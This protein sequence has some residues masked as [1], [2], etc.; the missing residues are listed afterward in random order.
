M[1]VSYLALPLIVCIIALLLLAIVLAKGRRR[2][3]GRVFS[4]ILFMLALYG[5]FTFFMRNSPDVNTP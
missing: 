3:A 1:N 4:F 5:L 2:P